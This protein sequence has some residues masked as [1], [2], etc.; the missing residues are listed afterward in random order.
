MSKKIITSI[1]AWIRH[2]VWRLRIFPGGGSGQMSPVCRK[3]PNDEVDSD[4]S[5]VIA[6]QLCPGVETG[7]AGLSDKLEL[8]PEESQVCVREGD[9]VESDETGV[10]HERS[11]LECEHSIEAPDKVGS[12]EMAPVDEDQ[13]ANPGTNESNAKESTQGFPPI[14]E[15]EADDP[16]G[17][18]DVLPTPTSVP[19]PDTPDLDESVTATTSPRNIGGRRSN[20]S[21][22]PA[23]LRDDV[24]APPTPKPEL[25]CR[26][27]PGSWR[28]DIILVPYGC[29]IAEV[30]QNETCLSV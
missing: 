3:D 28:W 18:T 21:K 24:G 19:L 16:G 9:A 20:H 1:W 25:I 11:M 6:T 17:I 22:R 29:S 30:R 26:M 23:K 15:A 27:R 7:N 13:L 14:K 4:E 8:K 2:V 10:H 12:D 5:L